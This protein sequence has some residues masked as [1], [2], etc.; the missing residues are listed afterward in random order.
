MFA[1][2]GN[3]YL[4]TSLHR[5]KGIKKLILIQ[6]VFDVLD[7][8]LPRDFTAGWITLSLAV[9]RVYPSEGLQEC[10]QCTHMFLLIVCMHIL[11][12][13]NLHG[14]YIRQGPQG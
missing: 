12:R 13:T 6:V 9:D 4:N 3:P 11:E 14:C 2:Q 5:T 8:E 1:M 10:T 7:G